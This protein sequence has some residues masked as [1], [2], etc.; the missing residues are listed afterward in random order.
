MGYLVFVVSW[1]DYFK[2]EWLANKKKTQL[3]KAIERR[4]LNF[5]MR[6]YRLSMIVTWVVPVSK[7]ETKKNEPI[8]N[9][10]MEQPKELTFLKSVFGSAEN[11]CT[12]APLSEYLM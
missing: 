3:L 9:S 4:N 2:F 10:K 1:G 6:N 11:G 5:K 7:T 8:E 12:W